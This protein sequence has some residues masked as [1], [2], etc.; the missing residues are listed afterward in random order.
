MNYDALATLQRKYA[1]QPVMF[2]LF[3][4]NQF[5]SQEP[6]AN[7]VIK[8]FAEKYLTLGEGSKVLMLSKTNVNKGFSGKRCT[9]TD[10]CLPSSK[11]CCEANNAVS[12]YLQTEVS[13]KCDWNFNKYPIAKT[14]V[15][16]GKRYGDSVVAPAL[17]TDID[18]LL[19]AANLP[20]EQVVVQ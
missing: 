5:L 9:S 11:D 18:A 20:K 6:N 1:K 12:D 19:E 2:F 3:P 17:S 13:G 15:P 8:T 10:G 16:S 14:G 7:S 4:C